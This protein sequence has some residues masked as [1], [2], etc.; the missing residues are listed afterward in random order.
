[1]D[2]SAASRNHRIDGMRGVAIL[3]VVALHYFVVAVP[4]DLRWR[5]PYL[6]TLSFQGWAGVDL[7]FVI[8]GFLVGGKLLRGEDV[9][10]FYV[11]RMGRILPLMWAL[12][13]GC[14]VAGLTSPIPRWHYAFL[15]HPIDL[16]LG[17]RPARVLEPLWSLGVE[18]WF[19]LCAPLLLTVPRRYIP[20]VCALLWT[21][22]IGFRLVLSYDAAWAFPLAR[23]D[24]LAAGVLL[25][26][27]G[28]PLPRAELAPI[29]I[30][31][32]MMLGP[33]AYINGGERAQYT[34]V[35]TGVPALFAW[36][37]SASLAPSPRPSLLQMRWLGWLG[38]HCYGIYLLHMPALILVDSPWLA[39]PVTLGAAH[40]SWRWLEA[41]FVR[42]SRR[43]A[44][45]QSP[46]AA[47]RAAAWPQAQA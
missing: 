4:M 10:G 35:A 24:G 41:P 21:A 2:P 18:E 46:V 26:W 9:L 16:G 11:K 1:M 5:F 42:W 28:R 27:W 23:L 7:F 8:S 13:L 25:A 40:L 17:I 38:R 37:L 31:L 47:D 43:W 15:L 14:A 3:A 34:F 20:S 32:W 30:L 36:W 6:F 29:F 39:V 44:K 45:A 12:L 33:L 22:S 19:Y